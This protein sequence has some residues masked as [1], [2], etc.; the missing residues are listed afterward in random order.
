ML[1]KI[2]ASPR[3]RYIEEQKRHQ[4]LIER[5]KREMLETRKELNKNYSKPFNPPEN[6]SAF[7]YIVYEADLKKKT[8][9]RKVRAKKYET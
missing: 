3:K 1:R 6:I 9:L 4:E 7:A 2:S 5:E 8:K